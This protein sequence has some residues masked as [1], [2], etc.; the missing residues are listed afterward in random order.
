MTEYRISAPG[1]RA[2]IPAELAARLYAVNN[3]YRGT[4][5][6]LAAMGHVSPWT[7]KPYSHV[8]IRKAIDKFNAERDQENETDNS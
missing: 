7:D 3:S 5:R 4:A 8:G 1:R 2:S 6:A